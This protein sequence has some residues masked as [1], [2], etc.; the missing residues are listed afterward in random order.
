MS[1]P[2]ILA[3]PPRFL[4]DDE[5]THPVLI[6]YH[7]YTHPVTTTVNAEIEFKICTHSVTKIH[8]VFL[9][10]HINYS[11]YRVDIWAVCNEYRVSRFII[12]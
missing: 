5:S 2:S 11:S 9:N 8:L 4:F 10:F 3:N 1:P 12:K 7:P 6:K